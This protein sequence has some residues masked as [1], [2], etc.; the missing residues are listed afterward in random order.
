MTGIRRI[1]PLQALVIRRR[2]AYARGDM[3]ARMLVASLLVLAG[4]GYHG[5]GELSSQGIWPLRSYRLV[6]PPLDISKGRTRFRISGLPRVGAGPRVYLH[7]R[8]DEPVVC[9]SLDLDVT[10]RIESDSG[11]MA[12]QKS[13]PVNDLVQRVAREGR[14]WPFASEWM[15][16][17]EWADESVVTKAVPID[18]GVDS[19]PERE[20]LFWSL[21]TSSREDSDWLSV[22]FAETRDSVTAHVE[23]REGWK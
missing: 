18:P 3:A 20:C 16:R 8:H 1:R 11:E 4:C 5:D 19:L 7:I 21:E 17:F 22:E 9:S 2:G 10:L 12:L 15:P 14:Q 6:L 13:G 23:L